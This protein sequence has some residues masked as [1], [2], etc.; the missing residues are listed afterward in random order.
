MRE[1]AAQ[2]SGFQSLAKT[3][4]PVTLLGHS[5]SLPA[6][7][8]CIPAGCFPG[9][10]PVAAAGRRVASM[11]ETVEVVV[12]KPSPAAAPKTSQGGAL[13]FSGIGFSV[14]AKDGRKQLLEGV[15]AEVKPGEV[16]AIMGPSGAGKTVL[17][18]ALTFNSPDSGLVEGQIALGDSALD[19]V[20]F[21]RECCTVT[22]EDRHWA[23]LT[24]E[25]IVRTAAD[26]YMDASSE[27]KQARVDALLKVHAAAA[28]PGGAED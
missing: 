3:C 26:L 21:T 7:A 5:A 8:R 11:E 19:E 15:T 17:M 24:A 9:L 12:E 18:N 28:L 27:V 20:T 16:L 1:S 10:A 2:S 22:Q 23:F 14:A 6:G 4:L 13:R 25:E